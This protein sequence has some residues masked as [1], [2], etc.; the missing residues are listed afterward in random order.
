MKRIFTIDIGVSDQMPMEEIVRVRIVNVYILFAI[1]AVIP[2]IYLSHAANL[3]S[4]NI[5][6]TFLV[7]FTFTWIL[8]GMKAYLVAK[9]WFYLCIYGYIFTVA[10]ILGRSAGLHV[11]LIPTIFGAILVFDHRQ[12]LVMVSVVILN[13][14]T[15]LVLEITGYSMFATSAVPSESLRVIFFYNMVLAISASV[16]AGI[17]YFYMYE[18][19]LQQNEKIV[20]EAF[21]L[22]KTISYFANSLFGKNTVDE[23]LWDVARNC[24]SRLGFEDCAVYLLDRE[25][26]VMVEKAAYSP[27]NLVSAYDPR[28]GE[29]AVGEGVVGYVAYT[30]ES[31]FIPDTT[32]DERFGSAKVRGHSELAVPLMYGNLVMGAIDSVHHEKN[33]FT[34]RHMEILQTIAALCANKVAGAL[35]DIEREEARALHLEAEKIKDFDDLKTKLFTN[36]SHELRTPLTLIKGSINRHLHSGEH[37]DWHHLDIQTDRLLRLSDQLLDLT[38]LESGQYQLRPKPRELSSFI[39]AIADQFE[40]MAAENKIRISVNITPTPLFVHFD[41]DALEKILYNLIANA[42]KYSNSDSTVE[43]RAE[44]LGTL[45]LEVSDAGQGIPEELLKRIFDRFYRVEKD[46][47]KGS[48]IGLALTYELIKLHGGAIRAENHP[49]GGAIIIADIPLKVV[50]SSPIE[51]PVEVGEHPNEPALKGDDRPV[52]LIVEDNRE[53]LR[54]IRDILLDQYRVLTATDGSEGMKIIE[55][56]LPDLVVCDV[57]MPE[58]NGLELCKKVREKILTQHIPLLMLTAKVDR[59]SKLEGLRLGADDYLIK[60]FDP[61]ELKLRIYN[62][63]ERKRKFQNKYARLGILPAAQM[64]TVTTEEIFIKKLAATIDH[65]MGDSDFSVSSL[66]TEMGMSRMQ[67]HR[68]ITAI[69]GHSVQVFIRKRR[70]QKAAQML[71]NGHFASVTAYEVGY[72]SLSHFSKVFKEEFGVS[73]SEYGTSIETE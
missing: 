52:V 40:Q 29:F 25:K 10:S 35:A 55:E 49:K 44:Y 41:S 15:F 27:E 34:H 14:L 20:K 21:E 59:A 5:S 23:I 24:I 72:N 42:I 65:R 66:S 38:H 3:P 28:I 56:H 2:E 68:K 43:V 57:M 8:Q 33:F 18:N 54:F 12:K 64:P 7:F 1:L 19:R 11:I 6:L 39:L 69:I 61:E 51:I 30:G 60:P 9:I 47:E 13:I 46:R 48:G 67:L 4:P 71:V 37:G 73:P 36:I 17:S 70:L 32:R 26:Q 22:E 31:V 53:I 50:N 45:H 58:M 63:L 16:V 62:H